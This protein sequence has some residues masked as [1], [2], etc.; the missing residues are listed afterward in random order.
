M[1]TATSLP[2]PDCFSTVVTIPEVREAAVSDVIQG[3]ELQTGVKAW[4]DQIKPHLKD[5]KQFQNVMEVFDGRFKDITNV[6]D[7]CIKD[8]NKELANRVDALFQSFIKIGAHF[9]QHGNIHQVAAEGEK[10][11]C[12]MEELELACDTI[13][14]SLE[15]RLKAIQKE[16]DLRMKHLQH[17]PFKQEAQQD[18]D[19]AMDQ[20][21]G[22]YKK[23]LRQ[24]KEV[25]YRARSSYA[26]FYVIK[27]ENTAWRDPLA[28][29][30]QIDFI[31]NKLLATTNSSTKKAFFDKNREVTPLLIFLM[32]YWYVSGGLRQEVIPYFFTCDLRKEIQRLRS[33]NPSNGPSIS[34][35]QGEKF[36][37]D[38]SEFNSWKRSLKDNPSLK[39]VLEISDRM[40][41]NEEFMGAFVD[42]W[43]VCADN[44]CF[45]PTPSKMSR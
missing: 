2:R 32:A 16:W 29:D 37:S 24:I 1:I 3:W 7:D 8:L 20:A 27:T 6:C 40:L 15:A 12:Q 38:F 34:F 36:F 30:Q 44:P 39:G 10:I 26:D 4:E 25:Q 28:R 11:D 22:I 41:E 35:V 14:L 5:K 23:N 19:E 17:N 13:V 9:N 21:R 45:V 42:C 33:E 31:K 18:Q 43:H